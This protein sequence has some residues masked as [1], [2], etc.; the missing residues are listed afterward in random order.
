MRPSADPNPSMKLA[1]YKD[2]SRD[3][4]LVVVS[5]DL[6]SAHYAAGIAGRLQQVLD[7]WNFLSPQLQDLSETLNGGKARHAF[8]FDPRLC[9]APLP[10]AYQWVQPRW[11]ADAGATAGASP[12][13]LVQG[14]A[15]PTLG[16][17]ATARP[18]AAEQRLQVSAGLAVITG[19][20][21]LGAGPGQALDGV[22]LLML[23]AAWQVLPA[24]GSPAEDE[25]PAPPAAFGPVVVTPDELGEAWRGGR[26]HAHLAWQRSGQPAQRLDA[27]AAQPW[28]FGELIAA[29]ARQRPLR[30]GSVVGS[31]PL[32]EPQSMQAGDTLRLSL[33]DAE[34]R[35]LLGSLEPAAGEPPREAAHTPADQWS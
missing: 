8:A 22:R 19:D 2:G 15:D 24:E 7:D 14:C 29:L 31:G 35:S 33:L 1:T 26:V 21:G 27:A 12:P 10:R 28:H 5:R 4:Q 20:V 34:G 30:S 16:P 32:F 11:P 9:L 18:P 25:P 23:A 3:G 17:H 6:G 13:R